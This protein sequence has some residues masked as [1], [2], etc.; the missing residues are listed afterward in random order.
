[1]LFRSLLGVRRFQST[2]GLCT[3]RVADASEA[4]TLTPSK[5]LKK[6]VGWRLDN[7]ESE[8]L[9]SWAK[10]PSLIQQFS[11]SLVWVKAVTESMADSPSRYF[12]KTLKDTQW[13]QLVKRVLELT[14]NLRFEKTS[15][16]QSIDHQNDHQLP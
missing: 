1:M 4:M 15:R 6:A 13:D 10:E 2:I 16:N 5:E 11:V 14:Q 8:E 7:E 12:Y 9:V 3:I